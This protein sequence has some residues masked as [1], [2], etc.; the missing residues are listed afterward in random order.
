MKL[1]RRQNRMKKSPYHGYGWVT[2]P[3]GQTM[4]MTEYEEQILPQLDRLKNSIINGI[5]PELDE[6]CSLEKLMQ[7]YRDNG[8]LFQKRIQF[9]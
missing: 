6:I 8:L 1:V 2:F 5:F 7:L 3:V 4:E 9:S